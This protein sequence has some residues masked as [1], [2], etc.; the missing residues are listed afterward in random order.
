MKIST[1]LFLLVGLLSAMLIMVGAM[2]LW[3]LD[4]ANSALKT[5]YLDRTI[6]MSE[7][8]QIDALTFATRMHVAQALAN[9][10]PDVLQSSIGAVEASQR[11]VD[12]QLE[13]YAATVHSRDESDAIAAFT[14]D[15]RI[16]QTQALAPAVEGLR[17]ND[18]T[19][20]QS[21]MVEKMTPLSVQLK[22]DVDALKAIQVD[23]AK[24]AFEQAV[25]RYET[26]RLLS[27]LVVVGGLLAAGVFG[28]VTVR[29]VTGQL[30]GEPDVAN[31]VTRKV[32]HGDLSSEITLRSG[33][34]S[35]LMAQLQFM[36]ANLARVVADVRHASE[37]VA[38]ASSEIAAGNNSLPERTEQ[39]AA[40]LQQTAASMDELGAAVAVN[41]E[42]A[43]QANQLAKQASQ[44]A[45]HGGAVVGQVVETMHAINSSAH[46]IV[47]IIS[48]IDG[49]AFQTNILALN[50]AVEAA[51]AGEQ[52]RGFAVVAS[53]VRSL[54][55]RSAEAAREIKALIGASVE[56]V[57]RGSALVD[58]AGSTMSDV[59]AS[60]TR[61]TDIMAQ[62]TAAS[63][64]QSNGV[65][66]V[67]E[68]VALIDQAT[69][70][71]A[72]MVEEIAAAASGLRS[73]A[74]VLVESVAVFNLGDQNRLALT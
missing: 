26:I 13:K 44:V 5:V 56:N 2:G 31:A 15:L 67:G 38:N 30:G 6:P 29:N 21:A 48:V 24:F 41:A 32:G 28:T 14:K 74:Q 18:I 69:Q 20:A 22:K 34:E 4:L 49:I 9:P 19:T 35:S 63:A 11:E 61:V 72:S 8:G 27:L 68:A 43:G 51:R 12:A 47:D 55:S 58:S 54:A 65:R 73:E 46:R 3:S 10:V 16:F 50:A 33:D 70:R 17:A 62:I 57:E 37:I 52:G 60:I 64:E 7:L 66:Q 25:S 40:A 23:Q 53:E 45:A 1:R 71:N 42:R 39:Q 36:Q 59:V